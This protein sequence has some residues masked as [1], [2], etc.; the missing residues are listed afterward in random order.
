MPAPG[1]AIR[2]KATLL[3]PAK[4]RN[5]SWRFLRLPQAASDLLPSRGMVAVDG[6]LEGQAFTATLEPDG[7]GGHWLKLPRALHAGG[8]I[9]QCGQTCQGGL[10][11]A[12]RGAFLRHRAG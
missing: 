5:A 6:T 3:R 9:R 8:R 2:C 7:E 1:F 11:A 4:P 12:A 10:R